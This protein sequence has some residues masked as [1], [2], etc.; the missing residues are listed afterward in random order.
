MPLVINGEFSVL[1]GN[2]LAIDLNVDVCLIVTHITAHGGEGELVIIRLQSGHRLLKSELKGGAVPEVIMLCTRERVGYLILKLQLGN[3]AF[4]SSIPAAALIVILK[5][6]ILKE[7]VLYHRYVAAGGHAPCLTDNLVLCNAAVSEGVVVDFGVF[8]YGIILDKTHLFPHNGNRLLGV[9]KH[10]R[11]HR[12]GKDDIAVKVN[13]QVNVLHRIGLVLY[14]ITLP[15]EGEDLERFESLTVLIKECLVVNRATAVVLACVVRVVFCGIGGCPAGAILF[16]NCRVFLPAFAANRD[17]GALPIAYANAVFDLVGRRIDKV[18]HVVGL[19][20]DSE[21][22]FLHT[23]AARVAKE[24]GVLV[25]VGIGGLDDHGL[26]AI[27]IG[28]IVKHV[29]K[30]FK[31]AVPRGI[32]GGSENVVIHLLRGEV[33]AVILIIGSLLR[34]GEVDCNK[35]VGANLTGG[36]TARLHKLGN[37]H[38]ALEAA[39]IA[40]CL[41]ADLHHAD[42]NACFDKLF[43]TLLGVIVKGLGHFGGIH[44]LPR[45]GNHLLCRVGP[46][47]GVMEVD[48]QLHAVLCSTLTD[49]DSVVD[50][51]V[52][53]AVA[54]AI[55]VIRIVPDSDTDVIY[56]VVRKNFIYVLL[57]AVK[58]VVFHT[59]F[60]KGGNGRCVHTHDKVLG[61]VLN[62]SYVK[63][64]GGD[65]H[66]VGIKSGV[67]LP[68]VT[69]LTG[70]EYRHRAGKNKCKANELVH[71]LH[72]VSILLSM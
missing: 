15:D 11:V 42:V 54:L 30:V 4:G 17:P 55:L 44:A 6:P 26:F 66:N 58:I 7:V 31:S 32:V 59:A 2:D 70:N 67:I 33:V 9:V 71:L 20:L 19:S 37:V 64:V 53:A 48:K 69:V 22:V 10:N 3:T 34:V 61:Q 38:P 56:A 13:D 60:L 29:G 24:V 57:C 25:A 5:G 50:I 36:L 45:L 12:L 40:V 41:I 14:N 68:L 35:G 52:T 63:A 8:A 43:K 39:E 21:W 1:L 28:N 51:T 16:P 65:V 23:V 46:E 47:V 18:N 72:R 62:L 27:G 49:L